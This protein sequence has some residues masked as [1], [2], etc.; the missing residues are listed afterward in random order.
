M[1]EP[2]QSGHDQQDKPLADDVAEQLFDQLLAS[3]SPVPGNDTSPPPLDKYDRLV[4]HNEQ[5]AAET[6][7]RTTVDSWKFHVDPDVQQQLRTAG[8]RTDSVVFWIRPRSISLRDTKFQQSSQNVKQFIKFVSNRV[9]TAI[10][11]TNVMDTGRLLLLT[12]DGTI[13]L[14]G[15][16]ALAVR[17]FTWSLND[18]R[19]VVRMHEC[20][21]NVE[22]FHA[23][24][25][26]D[27]EQISIGIDFSTPPNIPFGGSF[28]SLLGEWFVL[29]KHANNRKLLSTPLCLS[30]S[31]T[32]RGHFLYP[33]QSSIAVWISASETGLRVFSDDV[34][35]LFD[36]D[37]VVSWREVQCG[38]EAYFWS[39]EGIRRVGITTNGTVPL[40][41]VTELPRLLK[42]KST[43]AAQKA[44]TSKSATSPEH[45]SDTNEFEPPRHESLSELLKCFIEHCSELRSQGDLL[46]A[47]WITTSLL[48][49]QTL[50]VGMTIVNDV[51][52]VWVG[53]G[54]FRSRPNDAG[55]IWYEFPD[56]RYLQTKHGCFRLDIS[57][58]AF[59]L[60]SDMCQLTEN[61][62]RIVESCCSLAT[63]QSSTNDP[64]VPVT[65]RVNESGQVSLS[66]SVGDD[67]MLSLQSV[68]ATSSLWAASYG[69]L[70]VDSRDDGEVRLLT[71]S[72]QAISSLWKIREQQT[73]RASTCG[74]KLGQLYEEF[75][76]RRMEKFLVGVFGS[77]VV[78]HEQLQ[79]GGTIQEFQQELD[80]APAGPLSEE[81]N[82]RLVQKLSILEISR[83]Q[84]G[85][86]FDRCSLYLPHFWASLEQDWLLATF[87]DQLTD[88]L[89]RDREALRVRNTIRSELRQ[90]QA[91]VGR[92]LQELGQN[93]N[94]VSFAFPEEIRCAALASVRN[95]AGVAEKG[96][97]MTVFGGMGAQ[98]L[99][100]A[101]RASVGD[102]I[103]IAILGAM[104]LSLFGR[105]LQKSAQSKEQ[106]IRLRA[107]G[108]QALQWWQVIQESGVVMAFECRQTLEQL[109]RMSFDRDKNLL[110]KIPR[111]QLPVVQKRMVA[112]MQDW[113][114]ADMQSQFDEVL[115]GTGM[116]G[117]HLVQQIAASTDAEARLLI[118]RFGSEVSVSTNKE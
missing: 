112:T 32:Q 103:G 29:R 24:K 85:R 73:L 35:E 47:D 114:T 64:A 13:F 10:E 27:V 86:W 106:Q 54:A 16:F 33:F 80:L 8:L 6:G 111:E 34:D 81:L 69:Q 42:P 95:A 52:H 43:D 44:A 51:G 107:Y 1:D 40:P 2:P 31:H 76:K 18:F 67:E 116:F 59:D 118:K 97:M 115:P 45:G 68:S 66:R 53:D 100:G 70:H 83:Q 55:G 60:W 92:P 11:Q 28:G 7:S 21:L 108:I 63:I 91:S 113:L 65:L 99:L 30:A 93:L 71:A 9:S 96:A 4:S 17:V 48:D 98:L 41:T 75:S 14:V 46:V 82:A 90:L 23:E 74:V 105:H 56:G 57:S 87:G 84:I 101:G 77:L 22:L 78:T 36:F 110:E 50:S 62:V 104:G 109:N 102:P 5:M 19:I 58:D 61:R 72:R 117:H 12:E 26:A 79:S 20:E 88:K 37:R 15:Q 89:Q 38:I 25:T 94:A 49:D 39:E 3:D